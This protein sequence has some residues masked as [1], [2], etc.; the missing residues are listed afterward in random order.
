MLREDLY[1]EFK[2]SFN[3]DAIV[4]LAAFANA[5]GGTLYIGMKDDAT[6]CGVSLGPETVQH[7]INEI[8][9]KTEPSVIPDVEV[10]E[11]D[12]KQVVKLYVQE[13][14][15][16]PVSARGRY[17]R[18]Q[19]NSN[20]LLTAVEIADLSLQTRNVSWDAYPYTGAGW[21][22]LSEEKIRV[23][24][25]KSNASGRFSLPLN[26]KEA[27]EKLDMLRD[28]V[29]TNAAMLL[30]SKK[31]L[32]YN[33][34][35]GRFKSPTLIIADKMISGTLFEVVEES[36]MTIVS[37][38]KFAFDI[39]VVG[40]NTQRIEIPEYPLEA[41]R[42][43]LLNC[44]VHRD[45][46]SPTDVQIKI[47]DNSIVFFN[48]SGLYGNITEE[49]LKTDSYKASTRNR[50]IAEA[51]YLTKD[52][53]KYGSGFVRIRG[54]IADYPTM[55]FFYHNENYGFTAGFS[56]EVQREANPLI[57]ETRQ[58]T[59]ETGQETENTGKETGQETIETGKETGKE[60]GKE[61]GKEIGKE[62]IEPEILSLVKI[63]G[64]QTLT[65]KEI[66]Q[67]LKLK[68]G[69]NFRKNYLSPAIAGGYVAMLH[70]DVPRHRKQAY[71]LTEKGLSACFVKK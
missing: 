66:M 48:P 38:L 18:R 10:L 13:Y 39:R 59:K 70:P 32:H 65:V 56:Y 57:E 2:Q 69:D 51:F 53:E 26:P 41:I 5:K 11:M 3:E 54:L 46:Q 40:T 4:T 58:E 9:Q 52:I 34:H 71:Y 35:I 16:K 50:Q 36:M 24:I 37:H 15:V 7:W 68:G 22:D 21:D 62:R 55:Q 8:K 67:E 43:L 30:F 23:F 6:P 17:Y 12:G 47:F 49:D 20:H 25:G 19:A 42:E 63:I 45:Y 29:P 61:T 27:L 1:T 33:V 31:D 60:I 28:E 44:I 14:P 64:N